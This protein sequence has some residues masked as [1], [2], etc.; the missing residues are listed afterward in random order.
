MVDKEIQYIYFHNDTDL[1]VMVDGWQNMNS[2]L[3]ALVETRVEPRQQLI[4]YSTVGE[5]HMNSM[6][7][8]DEDIER[9]KCLEKHRI[10]GKF[11]SRPC[12]SGNYSWLEYDEPFRCIFTDITEE[13]LNKIDDPNK[14]KITG[15]ITFCINA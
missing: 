13:E 12:A 3:S 1:P 7:Y 2:G 14:N 9:W 6:F 15:K 4:V 11:R 8:D 5:W 10:I